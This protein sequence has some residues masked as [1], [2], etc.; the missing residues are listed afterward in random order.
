MP[1]FLRPGDAELIVPAKKMPG[2][3][4]D[5]HSGVTAGS[6]AWPN[7]VTPRS[8][9]SCSG[10]VNP[11]AAMTSSASTLIGS[12][13]S[14][15]LRST[16]NPSPT[17]L[18]RVDRGVEDRDPE[19]EEVVLERLHVARPDA[20]QRLRLD[21]GLGGRRRRDRDLRRPRREPRG[22]LEARVLLAD[23]EQPLA[24]VRRRLA[25]LGVVARVLDPRRARASTAPRCRPPARGPGVRYSPSVVSSVNV[26]PSG[27][28]SRRVRSQR[29]S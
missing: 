8:V 11:V 1:C 5:S 27:P 20:D 2:T 7:V 13:L 3:V 9:R 19:A 29:Q 12:P 14:V 10:Q 22:E 26:V 24:G 4:A 6:F 15:R 25:G 17:W 23:D 21:R 16:R 18:D 28:S